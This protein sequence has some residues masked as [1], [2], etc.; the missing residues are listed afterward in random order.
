LD[1]RTG[2]LK[3]KADNL[4]HVWTQNAFTY[5]NIKKTTWFR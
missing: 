5:M 2:L 3:K 4:C 1:K